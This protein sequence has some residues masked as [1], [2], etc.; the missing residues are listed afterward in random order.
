MAEYL[1]GE[2]DGI[3]VEEY[4]GKWSIIAM[5]NGYKEWAKYR[6]GKEKYADKDWTVKV[7]IGNRDKAIEVLTAILAEIRGVEGADGDDAPF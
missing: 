5:H 1:T 3:A 6:V 2:K 4:N 7:N